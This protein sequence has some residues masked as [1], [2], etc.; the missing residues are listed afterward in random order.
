MILKPKIVSEQEDEDEDDD[1]KE[2]RKKVFQGH[3]IIGFVFFL[4][5]GHLPILF[6]TDNIKRNAN[7]DD[8]DYDDHEN[9]VHVIFYSFVNYFKILD[10]CFVRSDLWVL[11]L[12]MCAEE[13][14]VV[15]PFITKSNK[16]VPINNWIDY[17]K[18]TPLFDQ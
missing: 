3:T 10:W 4:K 14:N 12:L 6:A 13:T 11:L 15:V 9:A 18:F 2:E 16:I 1:D 8:N 17:S 7:D 5:K